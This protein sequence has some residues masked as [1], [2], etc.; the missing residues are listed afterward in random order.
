MGKDL[1]GR[2][3]GTGIRQRKDGR[4]EARAV[5]QGVEISIYGLQ[6]KQLRKDF[7]KAKEQAKQNVNAKRSNIT[8]NEWFEEWFTK[9]KVPVIKETSIFPMKSKYY[10]TFGRILGDKKVTDILNIDIQE[11]VNTLQKEG[12]AASSMR[13]ALGRVRE[14][15]ESAK[16]NKIISENPCFEI[17]VPWE[18]KKKK[19]RFLSVEEQR[20]F[21]QTVEDNWYKEMFYFMCLT[22]VRVGELGGMKWSDI[23]LKKKVVHVRRS[24]SCSYY[25]G[26]KRMMLVTPKTVNSI[27]EI[28]F[29]G[30]MEEILKAQKKKQNKLKEE[31]GSRWRSTDDLKDLVFTTGMG[32]PCVRYVVEKEIKKALKRMSEKEGVLAVQENREPREIRDFHPHSLRHTFATRCFEKKMEPKVVQRLMGHSSISITLNIYTHV[33]DNIMEEEIKKFGVAKTQ[34]PEEY[35]NEEIRRARISAMSHC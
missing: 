35:Y 17:V 31:L 5:V 14:C 11:A 21:L 4:Y 20:L 3:L 33:L 32:S 26:E 9:C 25:N 34:T 30:E 15:L 8:L 27:R 28:P 29:L 22:G 23:D 19:I 7:E 18:N 10:N 24:L 16:R 6:L 2:E 13:D 12:R 1:K